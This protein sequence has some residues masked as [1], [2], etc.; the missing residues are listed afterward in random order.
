MEALEKLGQKSLVKIGS[1]TAKILLMCT[2]VSRTNF[3][4]TNVNVTVGIS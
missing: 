3:A 4:R 2:N 1:V